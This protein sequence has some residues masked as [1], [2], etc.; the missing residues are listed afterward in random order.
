MRGT[1]TAFCSRR[2]SAIYDLFD[3]FPTHLSSFLF[4]VGSN[5][6][7]TSIFGPTSPILQIPTLDTMFVN[8]CGKLQAKPSK[9][10]AH[11]LTPH[12]PPSAH[13]RSVR[14]AK[15][16]RLNNTN[17]LLTNSRPSTGASGPQ[18]WPPMLRAWLWAWQWALWTRW[19]W[20]RSTPWASVPRRA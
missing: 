18:A 14:S 2:I 8:K 17:I 20:V 16:S 3:R 5:V 12:N 6:S 4:R 10:T 11:S 15:C 7:S 19:A 1:N 13:S 9:K